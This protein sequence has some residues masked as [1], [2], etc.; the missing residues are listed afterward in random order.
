MLAKPLCFVFTPLHSAH[1]MFSNERKVRAVFSCKSPFRVFTLCSLALLIASSAK[2]ELATA[3]TGLSGQSTVL[4]SGSGTATLNSLSGTYK[5]WVLFTHTNLNISA[6]P[7]TV[8]LSIPNSGGTYNSTGSTTLQYQSEAPPTPVSVDSLSINL[9]GGG[10]VPVNLNID[11]IQVST[12]LGNFGLQLSFSGQ[13][14]SLN[15]ASN[16]PAD[17][18]LGGYSSPGT[19]EAV[20][21]GNVNATLTGVP[22]VGNISLGSIYTLD[23]QAVTTDFDLP[24]LIALSDLS[25]GNGPYPADMG[26][27]LSFPNILAGL[28]IPLTLPFNINQSA[29][30]P[31]GSSGISSLV[32]SGQI[33]AN[34]TIGSLQYSLTGVVPGGVAVPEFSS[35][36]LATVGVLGFAI[37]MW[38][39]RKSA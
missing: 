25:G 29:S 5:Q 10:S 14:S 27:G 21:S 4:V 36:G 17:A 24:G 20:I 39:R 38:R 22:L 11:P 32:A 13:I 28:V 9:L 31:N 7:Q 16:A 35:L 15:F 26:V 33:N 12:S 23:P 30:I 37:P 18:S 34:L 1:R 2:A 6:N 3:T 8:N 19:I